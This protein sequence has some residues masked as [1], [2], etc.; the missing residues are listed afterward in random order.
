MSPRNSTLLA[1]VG[2]LLAGIPLPA[3]TAARR[4]APA[5]A[6]STPAATRPVYATLHWSGQPTE[7]RLLHAGH[8]LAHLTAAELATTPWEGELMLPAA[9]MLQVELMAQWPEGEQAQAASL[10]LEPEGHSA[11]Q[12][13]LWTPPGLNSLHSLFSFTW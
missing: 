12:S 2:V 6:E 4:E 5:V 7:L 1:L 11:Q 8:E 3:L 10:T 9:P 13:T